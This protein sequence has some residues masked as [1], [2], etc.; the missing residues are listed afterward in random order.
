MTSLF[1]SQL[2]REFL[3]QM[4]QVRNVINTCLFFL[5]ILFIFPMTLK[6]DIQLLQLV[7][8]GLVW[9]AMLLSL[10][11][12][13][14]RLFQQDHDQGIIEQWLVSGRSISVIVTAKVIVHWILNTVPIILLTPIFALL[15]SLSF[16]NVVVFILSILCGT[17]AILFLSALAAA[18]GMGGNQKGALMALILLPLTLPIL[19]F[20]SGAMSIGMQGFPISGYLAIL[21]AISL[22]AVGF[23]P[24]AIA[25][26][27]RVGHAD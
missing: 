9:M 23:L 18:F 19:I 26:A 7:A 21:L 3:I 11:M 4:R 13:S 25:G 27:I 2:K 14:E 22:L 24:F 10:L 8:P 6:P 1:F 20:G 16:Q 17:P 15:F 12:S 5:M